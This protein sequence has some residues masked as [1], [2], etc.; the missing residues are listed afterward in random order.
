M[1]LTEAQ[2]A[3]WEPNV[4]MVLVLRFADNGGPFKNHGSLRNKA[5]TT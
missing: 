2:A 3:T 5:I 4:A 1:G